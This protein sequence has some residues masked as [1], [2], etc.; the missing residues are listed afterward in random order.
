MC[1]RGQARRGERFAAYGT[2]CSRE[3]AAP[4]LANRVAE[5]VGCILFRSR[6]SQEIGATGGPGR[7]GR[8]VEEEEGKTERDG[9]WVGQRAEGTERGRKKV[10]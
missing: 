6:P 10:L 2:A 9:S 7:P 8:R 4:R 1:S 5:F 3:I